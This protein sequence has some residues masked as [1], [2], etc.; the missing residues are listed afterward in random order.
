LAPG[1]LLV[2]DLFSPDLGSLLEADGRLMEASRW[3]DVDTG[4]TVQKL[5][6]RTV[7]LAT[8]TISVTFVYDETLPDGRYRTL[9]RSDA[10]LW[11]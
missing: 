2:V 5:Y 8:Q 10:L 9:A 7:D 4:A 1:G 6:T 3:M 11:R